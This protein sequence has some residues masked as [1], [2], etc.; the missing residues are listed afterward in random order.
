MSKF[1]EDVL[2]QKLTPE[3]YA[4]TQEAATEPAFTGKYDDFFEKG[5]YVD[6]A[7]GEP[8]FISDDKYNSGCGWPAFTKPV[9]KNAIKNNTDTSYGMIR[10]EV[11]SSDGNSHLGHVFPDGPAD[12]G[13][14]RYCINSAALKFIPYADLEK[15]GYG[16]YKKLIK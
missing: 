10:T 3:E 7:T 11:R 5:L 8:L 13:G 1:N 16:E 2:K 12:K 4:V 14:L 9:D 15:D 6:V